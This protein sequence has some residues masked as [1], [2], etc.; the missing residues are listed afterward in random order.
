MSTLKGK[1][2]KILVLL[3][4]SEP[5]MDAAD[6]ALYIAKEYDAK[7]T[8][9]HVVNS[10]DAY[11]YTSNLVAVRTPTSMDSIMQTARQEFQKW[12]GT[13]EQKGHKSN[14]EIKT[15]IIVSP[16]S[17]VGTIVD[18]AEREGADLIVIGTRGRSGFKKMLL[19]STASG[20]V[21]YA[22]CPVMIV[23]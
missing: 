1:I 13:V 16:G 17:T 10:G 12:F 20:V 4:G 6:Y 21:A 18:Y 5:S 7:L 23:K 8:A 9:L 15:D 14:V 11:R 3:D 19:G 22:C 2:S